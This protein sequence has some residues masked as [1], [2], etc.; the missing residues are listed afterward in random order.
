[1]FRL[2]EK[3][4]N[5]QAADVV[6]HLYYRMGGLLYVDL[7][8]PSLDEISRPARQYMKNYESIYSIPN[9]NIADGNIALIALEEFLLQYGLI[10]LDFDIYES[11]DS[12]LI[13]EKTKETLKLQEMRYK[14]IMKD[15]GIEIYIEKWYALFWN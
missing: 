4:S 5:S 12:I 6:I 10:I 15:L 13:V 11:F 7:Y 1:M 3:E 2:K 14:K 9:H 8:N